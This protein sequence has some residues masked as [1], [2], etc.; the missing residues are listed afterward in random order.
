MYFGKIN[1]IADCVELGKENLALIEEFLNKNDLKSLAIGSYPLNENSRVLIQE[2]NTKQST[3]RKYEAHRKYADVQ[4]VLRGEELFG[5]A[6]HGKSLDAY[7]TENDI[8]FFSGN[9]EDFVLSS[10]GDM[11]CAIFLPGELHAPGL[12]V[13]APSP[14]KKAVFKI[15]IF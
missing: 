15:R 3:E 7:S 14:V 5:V 8:E 9:G 2:Y 13:T 6:K 11:D 1:K 4:V 10:D 12:C